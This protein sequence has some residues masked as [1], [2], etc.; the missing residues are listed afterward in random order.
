MRL[1][2]T[3]LVLLLAG[4]RSGQLDVLTDDVVFANQVD[5]GEAFVGF[6]A[7][8]AFVVTNGS[9]HRV[10]LSLAAGAPFETPASVELGGGEQLEV[11]VTFRPLEVGAATVA[12]EVNSRPVTLSGLGVA[13]PSCVASSDCREQTFDPS[14]GCVEHVSVDGVVCG[15]SNA[16]VSGGT[17]QAGVCVGASRSCDDGNACT[18]DACDPATGCVHDVVT[19]APST[20]P[21]EAPSCD[22]RVG[23][24]VEAVADGTSCGPNDCQTAQVCL[25]GQCIARHAP[26]GSVCSPATGCRDEGRCTAQQRCEVPAATG[27]REAWR[28]RLPPGRWVQRLAVAASG[29]VFIVHGVETNVMLPGP[30]TLVSFDRDGRRRFEVDLSA[31]DPGVQNGAA[32]M[33]DEPTHRLYLASR[34][35]WPT[36]AGQ[37]VSVL[38]ARD[39]RTGALLWKRDLRALNI[40]ILN[41]S[42]GALAL[43][44]LGLA[45]IGHGDVLA[46]LSEGASIHQQ[47]VIAFDGTSGA[48]QWRV[49]RAGHGSLAVSGA[50]DV[51]MS[52]AACWSWDNRVVRFDPSGQARAEVQL[53]SNPLAMNADSALVQH[54]GGLGVLSGD[55]QTVQALPLPAGHRP[56]V[57]SGL[58]WANGDVT[59]LTTATRPALIRIDA[60]GGTIR[61]ATPVDPF[62][63]SKTLRLV[64]DGGTTLTLSYPDGGSALQ[65]LSNEGVEVERCWLGGNQ[66]SG[67]AAERL[68]SVTR[69]GVIAWQLPG[70]FAAPDGWTGQGGLDGTLRPR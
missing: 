45:S 68:F 10:T 18:T 52:W 54:D 46:H 17:C 24:R 21:C 7:P 53:L 13:V 62:A 34:T 3:A 47:H 67:L 38:A 25:S 36:A 48:E 56:D 31:E 69:D 60:V 57:W 51:W 70:L 26:E 16:C 28:L 35:Y 44:V 58:G 1:T 14:L 19:C 11:P 39:T 15:A 23:C 65:W 43:D 37:H 40:P 50:G 61:W 64:R 12:L 42:T 63:T 49:Q 8:C 33:V 27:P 66:V 59:T 41:S 32:L 2:L 30:L 9:R 6:S 22:A 20:N 4:C 55:L 29:D 5:C